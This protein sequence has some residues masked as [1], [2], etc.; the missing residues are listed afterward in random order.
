MSTGDP[1]GPV[2]RRPVAGGSVERLLVRLVAALRRSWRQLTSMRTALVLLFL[3]ALAAV[4]GSLLPQ[5]NVSP[6]QVRGYFTEHPDLAPVLDRLGFFDVY[7]S[8]WFAAIY[9]LL[10]VSLVGCLLPRARDHV[11]SLMRP[12]VD[13]P[14]N[15]SR[16]PHHV[17]GR[18]LPG[19]SEQ[20]AQELRAELRARRWRVAV[21][22]HPDGTATVSAE[23][24]YLKETGNLL[25]HFAMV[26][27]LVGVALGAAYGWHGNLAVIVGADNS[28][29]SRALSQYQELN[30][31]ARVT[32]AHDFGDFCL[33]LTDVVGEYDDDGV[34]TRYLA[35]A[36]V[37]ESGGPPRPVEFTVNRPLRLSGAT[38]YLF[39][40]G[41][42]PVL[43]YTDRYGNTQT[44]TVVF[45]PEDL[46]GTAQGLA[47][48]PDVNVAPD[49]TRDP[50]AQ[51]AFQGLYL[52][53]APADLET[54][55]ALLALGISPTSAH[56]EERSPALALQA[57]R[58]DLGL[59]T[60]LP[61]SL[62]VLDQE[63][64]DEGLLSAVGEPRFLRPGDTMTLDDGT[65]VEFVT[66]VP[67]AMLSV[68]YD[69]GG[70]V[71]LVGAVLL[72]LGLVGSL[73][74]R[75]QR[76]WFRVT[77]DEG[78]SLVEAGGLPRSEQPGFAQ[79]LADLVDALAP[80]RA[81]RVEMTRSG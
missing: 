59:D 11:A 3:L 55:D 67:T 71:A 26:V 10:F 5:R 41:Y 24:G 12:P 63:R 7:G 43:R 65:T 27:I 51:V 79:E 70:P 54:L 19:T 80:E 57:Y 47:L 20:A 13:A 74:G 75:R 16:L 17:G 48:F 14:R 44:D 22:T 25:M 77:P 1:A 49:G 18:V 72:I 46:A 23:R 69:P 31:G 8:P 9:L 81:V 39:G 76:V 42:A 4:P 66:T 73:V 29:C 45:F 68:R 62:Q 37:S 40:H 64:I 61:R 6:E 56:P 78:R 33:E 58:G 53:T 15:L 28:F 60:G 35:S 34:P 36:L 32:T 30:L 50:S 2:G 21:R 38:V 52:P